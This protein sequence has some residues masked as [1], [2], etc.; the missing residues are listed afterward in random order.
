VHNFVAALGSHLAEIVELS[1]RM[2][3]EGRDSHVEGGALHHKRNQHIT[4]I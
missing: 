3:I 1:F 4:H 2:L